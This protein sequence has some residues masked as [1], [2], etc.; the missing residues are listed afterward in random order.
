MVIKSLYNTESNK[1]KYK[2]I[3]Q[4][5]SGQCEID[6]CTFTQTLIDF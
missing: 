5:E 4:L 6:M 2:K 1:S 3:F